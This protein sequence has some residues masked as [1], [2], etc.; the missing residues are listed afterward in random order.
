MSSVSG[1][2]GG[3]L[4]RGQPCLHHFLVLSTAF[5]GGHSFTPIPP[6]PPSYI[7]PLINQCDKCLV[8]LPW[9][10]V[11]GRHGLSAMGA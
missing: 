2:W 8:P 11:D 4:K 7:F 5:S 9:G 1:Q 10:F 6:P 3:W